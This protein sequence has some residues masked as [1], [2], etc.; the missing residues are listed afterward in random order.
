MS[1]LHYPGEEFKLGRKK[2]GER[3]ERKGDLVLPVPASVVPFPAWG[4]AGCAAAPGLC[5]LPTGAAG[6]CWSTG[7]C[8]SIASGR[9]SLPRG[10]RDGRTPVWG[11]AGVPTASRL[12]RPGAEL[13]F[14]SALR[15]GR[16][17]FLRGFLFFFARSMLQLSF[18]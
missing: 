8:P 16:L 3:E 11:T 17:G 12:C 13:P 4:R 6:E 1:L 5:A 2:L 10:S 15:R 9:A 18:G 7:S 14:T